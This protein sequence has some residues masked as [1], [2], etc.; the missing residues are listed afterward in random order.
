MS[1][2]FERDPEIVEIFVAESLE[3]L[4]RLEQ[5]LL[6]AESGNP[7]DDLLDVLFRD[8]HTI[9]GT[10]GYLDY[11]RILRLSHVGEDLLDRMREGSITPRPAHF[12]CLMEVNDALREM[13]NNVNETLEEGTVAVDHL[14]A[15][16]TAF[17]AEDGCEAERAPEEPAPAA[18]APL[19]EEPPAELFAAHEPE[20]EA[21]P[22]PEAAPASREEAP[23]TVEAAAPAPAAPTP[24]PEF[25][26]P[27]EARAPEAPEPPSRSLAR[28]PKAP[29]GGA[30]V[31]GEGTVRV[32]VKVLDR[33]MNLMGELVLAR[34]Q[35]VQ[36]MTTKREGNVVAQAACQRLSLVT[37]EIQEEIMKSRMQPVARVFERIPRIIRDLCQ[38]TG[39]R[40]QTQI[41]GTTTEIDKALVEVIRD[42]VMHVV[43]NAVDHGIE[44]PE[45]R[46][47]RGKPPTGC[48]HVRASHEGG[49]VSIEI[50][51][52]GKG[53]DPHFLRRKAVEKGLLSEGEASRLSDREAVDLIFQP[54]FST[55]SQVTDISGRGVGMDV[56]RTNLERSGGT[57]EIESRV[58]KGT[59]IRFRMP[60]TLAIIPTLLVK[61]RGHRF[62]IPQVNL[63]EL[64][65][66]S[67]EDAKTAIEHVRGAEIYRLRGEV[68]PLVRLNDVLQL[69]ER[70][71][72]RG[73]V[74]V[75]VVAVGSRRYGLI[76]DEI[77]ETEEIVIK[78]LHGELRRLSCYAGATVL[79]DGGVALIIEV[80]GVAE[81]AGIDVSARDSLELDQESVGE[82]VTSE[83]YMLCMAGGQQCA[84]PLGMIARLERVPSERIERVLG[85][86]V[87]QY[88]EDLLTLVRPNELFS[89]PQPMDRGE[90]L[91]LIVF[92]FGQPVGMNVDEILDVVEVAVQADAT[93]RS[94]RY[95]Q[96]REVINGRTTLVLDVYE[97]LRER[98]PSFGSSERSQ[99]SSHKGRVLV[100][101]GEA[102]M[103]CATTSFLERQGYRVVSLCDG[104]GAVQELRSSRIHGFDALVIDP[105]CS[106]VRARELE[107]CLS[108]RQE[109]ADLPVVVFSFDAGDPALARDCNVLGEVEVVDK[110]RREHLVQ[111]LE[112][113]CGER[114]THQEVAA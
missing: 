51:D 101:D 63:L 100:V 9:K 42:P 109:R 74:N 86:E 15:R 28:E 55:A 65:Y 23:Q 60:L 29:S 93:S 27:A 99:R 112:R 62:A 75:V 26:A 61:S 85:Q 25:H 20:V 90:E 70:T 57:A 21:Q 30:H 50:E 94:M 45:A 7:A 46:E 72:Q 36:L 13:L 49:M 2:D 44:S 110:R 79:G 54:G 47:A 6:D 33:L 12:S 105:G 10:S 114:R 32:N 43:R 81:M 18:P 41:D 103:R 69:G 37:S 84:V 14:V 58:G 91:Q 78:P 104:S 97:I 16:L 40:V 5:L 113:V 98:V 83:P 76:V 64:V 48:L 73:G 17:L 82:G 88:R 77:A 38:T 89:F 24:E 106:P 66:L 87:L 108:A 11:P 102:A 4:G 96:G 67:E 92:D 39:K 111:A 19:A 52:D 56:V 8:V 35:I 71:D 59:T 53:L 34:N 80:S 68:L 1:A 22:E 107:Q 3:A 31:S 95:V